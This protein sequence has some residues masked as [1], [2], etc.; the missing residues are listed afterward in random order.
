[1]GGVGNPPLGDGYYHAIVKSYSCLVVMVVTSM[2]VV[3]VLAV[4]V[5]FN[6]VLLCHFA[7]VVGGGFE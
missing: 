6:M 1:M 3:S 5:L 2:V 4:V 7:V